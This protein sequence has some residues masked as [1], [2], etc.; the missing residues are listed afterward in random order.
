MRTMM[1]DGPWFDGI[2][3]Y[4]VVLVNRLKHDKQDFYFLGYY[5]YPEETEVQRVKFVE[6]SVDYYTGFD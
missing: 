1:Y 4:I 6:G 2:A 5:N 3:R